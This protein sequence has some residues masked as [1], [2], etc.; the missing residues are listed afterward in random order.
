[1]SQIAVTLGGIIFRDFE[2]PERIIFGGTQS[3][4][5]HQLFGGGRMIE[6]LGALDS[7][8]FLTGIF[9]GPDAASRAQ[10]LNVMRESG[11]AV[12]L[13]W[14]EFFYNVII[15]ELVFSFTKN[16]WIP[17]RMRLVVV[18][19]Y[20]IEAI[21][22]IPSALQQANND[23]LTAAGFS[24][25]TGISVS[26]V[27]ET[28]TSTLPALQ[29]QVGLQIASQGENLQTNATRLSSGTDIPTA[30]AALNNITAGSLLLASLAAMQGPINRA[31]NNFGLIN[32]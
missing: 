31:A 16:W 24:S 20:V 12:A 18:R 28:T 8:V 6:A 10:T 9:S 2:V 5:V 7:E 25:Q 27:N 29:S 15:E 3:L 30:L 13:I 1:M 22:A 19:D 23:I 11:V 4:A 26:G 21:T 32:S 17:F 14:D